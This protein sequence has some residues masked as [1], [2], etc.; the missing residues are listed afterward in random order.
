M[1]KVLY[2]KRCKGCFRRYRKAIAVASG[3]EKL[4]ELYE[5]ESQV[6]TDPNIPDGSLIGQWL[7]QNKADNAL[8]AEPL[9][10]KRIVIVRRPRNSWVFELLGN[11]NADMV[12]VE[13][14]QNFVFGIRNT[15]E[16]PFC[17]LSI[18]LAEACKFRPFSVYNC[19]S[20]FSCGNKSLLGKP[21]V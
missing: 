12:D 17:Y 7:G 6:N 15:V 2:R 8:F 3:A 10:E 4:V 19:P 13:E 18:M 9:V 20:D 21:N 11:R 14:K 1:Q 16:V 5:F